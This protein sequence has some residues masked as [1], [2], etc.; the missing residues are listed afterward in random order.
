MGEEGVGRVVGGWW[1]W[2]WGGVG[3]RR[4]RR[5]GMEGAGEGGKE[6]VV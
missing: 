3:A 2:W 6:E 5:H 1:C 4:G